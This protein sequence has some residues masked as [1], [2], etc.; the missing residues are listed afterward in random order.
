MSHS[1]VKVQ[2]AKYTFQQPEGDWRIH[3]LRYGNPWLVIESGHKAIA[4]L[5]YAHRNS[6]EIS[7]KLHD[8]VYEG[9]HHD[10]CDIETDEID[11]AECDCGF[12]M[13][14]ELSGVPN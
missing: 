5:L 4:A 14:C 8:E 1:D 12:D 9:T 6:E 3:V 7:I 2:G 11:D 10:W 13:V